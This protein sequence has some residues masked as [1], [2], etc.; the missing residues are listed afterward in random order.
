[1][2]TSGEATWNGSHSDTEKEIPNTMPSAK[3]EQLR[4]DFIRTF[5]RISK[6]TTPGDAALL[7]ILVEAPM[8]NA[9]W[10][11][12]PQPATARS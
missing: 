4:S 9:G 12:A 8:P 7:R 11:S 3:L 1:M 5:R 10:K 2:K 6:N